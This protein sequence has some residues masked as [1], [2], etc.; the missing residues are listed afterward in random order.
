MP[1]PLDASSPWRASKHGHGVQ[2]VAAAPDLEMQVRSRSVPR[3]PA[4]P[5][6]LISRYG[7]A[8]DH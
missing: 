2:L 1:V 5:K 8:L 4:E 3:C 7:L 6:A